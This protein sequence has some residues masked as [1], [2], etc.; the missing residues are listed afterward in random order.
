M[1][2]SNKNYLKSPRKNIIDEQRFTQLQLGKTK[3]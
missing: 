1:L 2:K 3:T